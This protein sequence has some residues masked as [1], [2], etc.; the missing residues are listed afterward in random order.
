MPDARKKT[1]GITSITALTQIAWYTDPVT[2]TV[3]SHSQAID[4]QHELKT[5]AQ[6]HNLQERGY[7]VVP[8]QCN[9]W[10]GTTL[11]TTVTG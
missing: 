7:D 4:V 6:H 2:A 10:Y 9:A 8:G 5:V 1:K 3:V 11:G